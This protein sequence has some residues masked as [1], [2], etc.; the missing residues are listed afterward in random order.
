MAFASVLHTKKPARRVE[1]N[2]KGWADTG[3]SK[4]GMDWDEA[5]ALFLRSRRLGVYGAQHPVREATIA[6][7]NNA[8][9][10]IFIR[11]MR[12]GKKHTHYN[13]MT[14][15][16]VLT[17]LEWGLKRVEKKEVTPVTWH[18][19]L[20]LLRAF[21][22]WVEKDPACV[23]ACMKSFNSVIGKIPPNT[24]RTWI[25][26][27]E[28]MRAFL[29]GFDQSVR[30]GLRDY[31]LTSLILDCGARVG[32]LCHLRLTHLH[33]DGDSPQILIP[34]EG[35]TGSRIVPVDKDV[36]VPLLR[37]WMRD[38]ERYAKNDYV[39]VNKWGGRL[40]PNAV[41]QSY[42]ENRKRLG[43]DDNPHEH[44]T[45]H[46]VRHFF[47]THYLVNGGT[48]HNLQRITGHKTLQ[49]LMIYVHLANQLNSVAEEHG[50]V[51]PLKNLG[52]GQV[53]LKKK[54]KVV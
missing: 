4:K 48:L 36:T 34:M 18:S 26:T 53:S 5:Y 44:L 27:P 35:K 28:T 43:I 29:N 50:R 11:F 12:D 21:F 32:E 9:G 13:Q 17:Y 7:Y 37:R 45:V 42:E 16:D 19:Y 14:E 22:T 30:W 2:L 15:N 51:S 40:T 6:G 20:R 54:R 52:A 25:A 46:T 31:V 8:I 47:C 33:I 41:R 1:E 38:R 39:F 3:K 24:A 49:T 23:E 10:V